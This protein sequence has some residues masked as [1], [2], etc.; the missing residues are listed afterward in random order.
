MSPM[1]NPTPD[2]LFDLSPEQANYETARVAVL[3][4][5]YDGTASYRAGSRHGP[6]AL[7]AA[8]A[9][10]E[11]YDED[12]DTR[13]EPIGI[14]LH[15]PVEVADD[16]AVV[17]ERV[18]AAT[19][20]LLADGKFPV[21]LGGDH[22]AVTTGMVRALRA[23]D[24]A[25]PLGVLIVDAHLDLRDEY[26]GSRFSHACN[27]RRCLELGAEVLTVGARSWSA[28]EE[29]FRQEQGLAPVRAAEVASGAVTA[30]EIVE[31][32]PERVHLS[33]DL[34]GLDPAVVPAVGTPEPGGLTWH[35]T[36]ALLGEL[37]ARR[38]VA[39]ADLVEL[40]P[41][42]GDIRGDFAAARLLAKL[43]CRRC[44]A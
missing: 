11:T 2:T 13:L 24:D 9:Q 5:P 29:A 8:S 31:R 6:A 42:P 41:L 30:A 37:C 34:D 43:L 39:S 25:T 38:T 33:L 1:Q 7:I 23:R 14:H 18:A 10:V 22:T 17:V 27:A 26:Q 4:V 28:G 21:G 32:L 15:P 35:F 16:P 36:L 40:C 20:R 44:G 3:P 19:G 12:T